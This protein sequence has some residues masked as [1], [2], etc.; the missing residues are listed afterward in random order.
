MAKPGPEWG[1]SA[2]RSQQTIFTN[3]D[4]E[5][6]NSG[7]LCSGSLV[8]LRGGSQLAML[9]TPPLLTLLPLLKLGTLMGPNWGL[10]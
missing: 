8:R 1:L 6:W 9:L 3:G 10:C 7:A 4:T 5:T 2:L